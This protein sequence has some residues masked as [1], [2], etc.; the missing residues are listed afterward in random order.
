MPAGPVVLDDGHPGD[1]AGRRELFRVLR[2]IGVD[3][4]RLVRDLYLWQRQDRALL[5]KERRAHVYEMQAKAGRPLFNVLINKAQRYANRLKAQGCPVPQRVDD[6]V[7][8]LLNALEDSVNAITDRMEGDPPSSD[9]RTADRYAA[10]R[11]LGAQLAISVNNCPPPRDPRSRM[12]SFKRTQRKYVQ[13]AYRVRNW[14]EYETGL[15]ARGSLTVWLGLTDGKLANWNSPRP[16]RRKP[17][18]QRK[19]S[20]HAI[21]T[22]VTLGLVFGLA[23]RQTEGFLRSLLTLLNL[24]NDVPDHST[25]SRR[26]ARLGKVASYKRR[27]VKPVHLL[28]DSS[29]LSVHVGQLRTPPKARDYRKLHLAVDEQTSDVVACDLTSKRARDA[30]RVASLVGQIER[31]IASAKADAAYDTGDVYKTL[32]NH[33]AHRSPKVLIPPR[34]GAQLAL[35]SAGTRQRNRNIRARSRVGKRKWYVA[36]GYSRRSKVETTFH[37]YKAILGSAMRARGLASQRVEVRLGCKI[38][39]TMTALGIPDGEMIG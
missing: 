21:E 2:A 10:E 32:E 18:R 11:C 29:G 38:L 6:A 3:V 27:T 28:I 31:P 39:N 17:G 36:S 5:I 13:K 20:N 26:K 14:R 1:L 34:K 37:R 19:Y 25:I 4:E 7:Y 9:D 22:T 15:C 12:T 33:R 35:D 16:T 8:A 23:S 24:D 30:S